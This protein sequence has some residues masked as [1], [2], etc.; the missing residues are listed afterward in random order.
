MQSAQN[1]FREHERARRQSMSGFSLWAESEFARWIQDTRPQ[2]TMTSAS[3]VVHDPL[4]QNRTKVRSRDRYQP[5]QAFTP[6]R[7]DHELTDRFRFRNPK[8]GYVR[9]AQQISQAFSVELD[10]DVVRR[11]LAKHYRCIAKV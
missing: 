7:P 1:R 9:I 8:F 6:Y 10:K 2:R 3:V 11:V 4:F 5:T